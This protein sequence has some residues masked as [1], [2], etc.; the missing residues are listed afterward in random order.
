[1][2]RRRAARE[3]FRETYPGRPG[4]APRRLLG[5]SLPA[6]RP[7]HSATTAHAQAA[8]PFMAE[9]GLGGRG[10]YIGVDAY[11]GSF[12]FDPWVLYGR[13]ITNPNMVVLGQLGKGKSALV[14]T[15][16]LRQFVFGRW[17][18]ILDPKGEYTALAR[19]L[20]ATP[21][22]LTPGGDVR[23]NPLTDRAGEPAQQ[24]LLSAV[25]AASLRRE[26]KPEE[27]AAS[28]EALR[29][30]NAADA[31]PT[32]PAVVEHLL[33]P[34]DEMARALATE[35]DS[36][37]RAAR[38]A[39]LA[40]QRLCEGDLRG[41]FDGPTS[42]GL[43]LEAPL[44]V[45]DLSE[46]LDSAAIGILMACAAAWQRAQIVELRRR[47]EE[48]GDPGRKIINV[49]DEGWRFFSHLGAARWLQ[50]AFKH[51]RAY[52][53][54]NVI[55]MHRLSDLQAAGALGSHE[56][57]LAEGLVSDT[58]TRVI[59]AQSRDQQAT[60]R[61]IL[62]LS[63]TQL[64]LIPT[65]ARGEALWQVGERAFLVQHRLS[66]YERPLVDTDARM[67]HAHASG[68]PLPEAA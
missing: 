4:R 32:L 52:G 1:V 45:I 38:E 40:L 50:D 49:L 42:A 9:G 29:L 56:V 58:E 14:K 31:E 2:R 53:V 60:L 28:R 68:G 26:L 6:E 54:Q 44:V 15:M 61:E 3:P 34:R 16:L 35:R 18:W 48:A 57:R 20:G 66:P 23:L 13:A 17:A 12:C 33:H 67:A 27:E 37:A 5:R 43:E 22:K 11:G 25:I 30:L 21:I 46:M 51:A 39:A 59:Y 8:Y 10:I 7:G 24:A 65:L 19:A 55:V 47:A 62:A 41:M 36:L 63:D 64:E